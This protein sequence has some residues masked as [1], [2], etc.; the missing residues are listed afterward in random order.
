MPACDVMITLS[1]LDTIPGGH[2]QLK[3]FTDAGYRINVH[4]V[5]RPLT[6]DEVA[7]FLP[8]VRGWVCGTDRFTRKALQHADKLE[9][10]A[11]SG[12]G[13]D[14]IDTGACD[15]LGIAVAITPGANNVAVAEYTVGLVFA[16]ARQIVWSDVVTRRKKWERGL[17]N[18]NSPLGKTLGIIGFNQI[19]Q[20]LARIAAPL[21]MKLVYHDILGDFASKDLGAKYVDFD[22]LLRTSDFVSLHVPLTPKTKNLIS[23][24]E[25]ELMKPSAYLINTSR[26][27][28]VDEV[29]L[30]K[31]LKANAIAG[32]ALDVFEQEPV[33]TDSPLFELENLIM[34]PHMAGVST[35]GKQA[36]LRIAIDNTL[37]V[38]AG[39][40]PATIVN[41]PRKRAAVPEV[42]R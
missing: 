15:D 31:A 32:A 35:E 6:E 36:M 14:A 8:G 22:E 16:L 27:S 33:Q 5:P 30:A 25:F 26:G 2:E 11:R 12:V 13:Y 41:N 9:I 39:E 21:G 34:T 17:I 3:R 28:I 7:A 38:L 18:G 40:R 20:T 10:L 24:R 4:T 23:T 19:G 42:G 1:L 37:A 29:A